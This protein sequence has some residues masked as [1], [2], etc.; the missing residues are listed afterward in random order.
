MGI[1]LGPEGE[2]PEGD[3]VDWLL[4]A[5]GLLGGII[6]MVFVFAAMQ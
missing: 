3:D 1:G 5:I 6:V 2:P 4:L